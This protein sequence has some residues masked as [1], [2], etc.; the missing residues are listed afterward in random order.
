M[1]ELDLQ[2]LTPGAL[3][4]ASGL[5]AIKGLGQHF[6][7]DAQVITR[8]VSAA[9]LNN[10]M[11]V[12][13][14]GSGPGV[15]TAALLQSP[16]QTVTAIELDAR[17]I[18]HVQQMGQG[19]A[20]FRVL[21]ENA[22]KTNLL[23]EVSAPRVIVANL[24]Y[25]AGT[26][27][28]VRWLGEWAQHSDAYSCMVLMF[29][30]EV[31]ERLVAAPSSGAYGRLSVLVQVV[32]QPEWVLDVPAGAFV[33]PPKVAS[34]V[35]RLMPRQQPLLAPE[36]MPYLERVTASAFNQRRKM[37]RS[38]LKALGVPVEALL[39]DASILPTWRAEQVDVAGFCRLAT[40]LAK[41]A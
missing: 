2:S 12:V 28:L 31:A 32:T 34:A 37:L 13:E 21:H 38:S 19:R 1:S 33:P 40:C 24:P 7:H 25:N 4:R 29:Q 8:I 6:L 30:K 14:I 23:E 17:A 36:Y 5:R 11:H 22:L 16:A 3:I 18:A 15:L 41:H 9:C 10:Q 20:G 39:D 26:A 27:M 35:V